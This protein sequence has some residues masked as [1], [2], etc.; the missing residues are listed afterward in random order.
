MVAVDD[1]V[2]VLAGVIIT[3]AVILVGMVLQQ[4][5][6]KATYKAVNG[7]DEKNGEPVLIDQVRM[8]GKQIAR[9]ERMNEWKIGVLTQVAHQVGVSV[10]ALPQDL[11]EQTTR[12]HAA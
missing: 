2:Y 3:Q 5:T 1:G 11:H 12:E 6:T 4:R 8:Q 10:P 9:L 7:V